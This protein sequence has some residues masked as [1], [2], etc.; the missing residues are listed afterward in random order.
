MSEKLKYGNVRL[1]VVAANALSAFRSCPPLNNFIRQVLALF[2]SYWWAN[3]DAGVKKACRRSFCWLVE[4]PGFEAGIL[5][6]LEPTVGYGALLPSNEISVEVVVCVRV[7]LCL[8][9]LMSTF[10]PDVSD[11]SV[12]SAPIT[13][14]E[15]LKPQ[16]PVFML[17]SL[18]RYATG[19]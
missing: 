17:L 8:K 1:R 9:T 10:W 16:A 5:T 11:R 2:P 3:R 19:V 14:T 4:G 18:L 13:C 6:P 15:L 7:C 12:A